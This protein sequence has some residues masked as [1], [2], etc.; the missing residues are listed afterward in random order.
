M[1]SVGI[2]DLMAGIENHVCLF[3]R[4]L[5]GSRRC[6]LLE[7]LV[8]DAPCYDRR[9]ITVAPDK[10]GEVAL[11]PFVEEA[12][13][14]VLCFLSAPHVEAFVEDDDTHSVA[15]VEQLRCRRVMSASKGV[16]THFLQPCQLTVHGILVERGTESSEVMMLTDTIEFE[17]AAVEPESGLG[18]KAEAAESGSGVN[19]INSAATDYKLCLDGVDIRIGYRPQM[20]PTDM[21]LLCCVATLFPCHDTLRGIEDGATQERAQRRATLISVF[22]IDDNVALGVGHYLYTPMIEVQRGCCRQPYM[23]VDAATAVP[24]RVRLIAVVDFHCNDIVAGLQFGGD[25]IFERTV[26]V[27]PV[28]YLLAVDIDG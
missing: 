6:P 12:G 2:D 19:F 15:H 23:T 9:M 4:E 24:P 10:V 22:G 18:I 21:Q 3:K 7:H 16:D 17:V 5:V 11:M 8:A 13:I 26:S 14:V 1:E 25:V 27:W 28:P 20:R